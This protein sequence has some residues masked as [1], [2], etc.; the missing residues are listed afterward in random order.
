MGSVNIDARDPKRKLQKVHRTAYRSSC[1][2][3]A[4]PPTSL[5]KTGN[6]LFWRHCVGKTVGHALAL[7]VQRKVNQFQHLYPLC[8][9]RSEDVP[10]DCQFF[11]A[12]AVASSVAS[13]ANVSHIRAL[14]RYFSHAF[15]DASL[16]NDPDPIFPVHQGEA[17]RNDF[18]PAE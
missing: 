15:N 18:S 12:S 2:Q 14:S 8:N 17:L 1:R 9:P 6:L 7:S 5:A 13:L 11:Q 10:F 3:N 4:G 16:P